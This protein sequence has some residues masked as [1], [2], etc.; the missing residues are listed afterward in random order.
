MLDYLRPR[1]IPGV[2][3]VAAGTYRRT[4][5]TGGAPG[6]IE[7]HQAGPDRLLLDWLNPGARLGPDAVLR[8]RRLFRLDVDVAAAHA[9][10]SAAL[11]A[12]PF[13][14]THPGLR[15][16]GA[17]DLNDTGIRVIL[18]QQVTVTGATT[19]SRRLVSPLGTRRHGLEA[20]GLTHLFPEP[21]SV[22]G[23]E[24]LSLGVPRSR[25]LAL[26]AFSAAVEVGNLGLEVR[27]PLE[28]FVAE[29]SSLPGLGP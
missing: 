26:R 9:V 15:P 16:L 2:Q 24:L 12:S 13:L 28:E 6:A 19:L 17:W 5:R 18:G 4:I 20:F 3:A 8:A 25:Q 7:V 22:A 27:P 23:A 21:V 10:V 11:E 29:I 14:L 1:A